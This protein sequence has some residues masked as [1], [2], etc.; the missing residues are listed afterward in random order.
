MPAFCAG[1]EGIAPRRGRQPT[2]DR[3]DVVASGGGHPHDPHRRRTGN[4][5]TKLFPS[6]VQ[7]RNML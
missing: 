2:A 6:S 5:A 3:G 7:R 4:V 1:D